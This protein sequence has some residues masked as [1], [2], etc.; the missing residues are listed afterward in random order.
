MQACFMSCMHMLRLTAADCEQATLA[1]LL[2]FKLFALHM[3]AALLELL[4]CLS[5]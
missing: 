2:A 3:G 1:T 5:N 4:R